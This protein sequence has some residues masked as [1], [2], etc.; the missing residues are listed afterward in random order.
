[1][2]NLNYQ[3]LPERQMNKRQLTVENWQKLTRK[4]AFFT[5]NLF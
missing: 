4:R 3:D 1:V 5:C 2:T